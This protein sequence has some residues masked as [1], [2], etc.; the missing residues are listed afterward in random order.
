MGFCTCIFLCNLSEP[1]HLIFITVATTAAAAALHIIAYRGYIVC[2]RLYICTHTN[3]IH[4]IWHVELWQSC[5]AYPICAA[6]ATVNSRYA[7][8]NLSSP[9]MYTVAQRTFLNARCGFRRK[10]QQEKTSN[11]YVGRTWID[12]ER[13]RRLISRRCISVNERDLWLNVVRSLKSRLYKC[14]SDF[15]ENMSDG[16]KLGMD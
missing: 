10:A 5:V 6:G 13:G 2:S 4:S 9:K 8:R 12:K 11:E 14:V 1:Q 3:S 16:I 15:L 7:R